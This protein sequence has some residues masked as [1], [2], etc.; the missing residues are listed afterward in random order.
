MNIGPIELI[1]ICVISMFL[2][3][4]PIGVALAIRSSVKKPNLSQDSQQSRRVPCP[5]CAEL[6]LPEA[7]ICRYCGKDLEAKHSN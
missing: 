1:M 4:I 5:Y 7:K 3:L 2:L 6:I